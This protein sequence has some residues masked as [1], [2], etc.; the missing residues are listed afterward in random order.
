MH[1]EGIAHFTTVLYEKALHGSCDALV[2]CYCVLCYCIMCN[3]YY[4]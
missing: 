1:S 4:L 2:K 3:E